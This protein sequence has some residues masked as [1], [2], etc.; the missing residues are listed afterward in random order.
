[1]L[2]LSAVLRRPVTIKATRIQLLQQLPLRLRLRVRLDCE[3]DYDYVYD[4][5]YDYDCDYLYDGQL[6]TTPAS[7]LSLVPPLVSRAWRTVVFA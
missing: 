5:R 1:M 7:P 2:V 6:L 3:G 4:D